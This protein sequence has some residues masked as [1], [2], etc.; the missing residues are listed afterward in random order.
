MPKQLSRTQQVAVRS[1]WHSNFEAIQSRH[2]KPLRQRCDCLWLTWWVALA[3]LSAI[4]SGIFLPSSRRFGAQW[5]PFRSPARSLTGQ[6]DGSRC[7]SSRRW[8]CV[9]PSGEIR[10]WKGL[11]ENPK[12]SER[13]WKNLKE[14]KRNL[15][16]VKSWLKSRL[17]K[18]IN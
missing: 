4:F 10:I 11:R 2:S 7:Q 6:T 1:H 16:E 12:E 9:L 15:K 13:V 18:Q 14:S 3:K 8:Q 17:I 5:S